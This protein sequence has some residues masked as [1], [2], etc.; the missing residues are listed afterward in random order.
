M[1]YTVHDTAA[2]T[3]RIGED[4]ALAVAAVRGAD[5]GL[6][7]LVL[8]GG[9]ARGEGMV[10]HG[11]P[12]NDYDFVAVRSGPRVDYE[13]LR[14]LLEG[15]LGLH[16]DLARV[17][18]AR[19]PW[20]RPSVFWYETALRGR[21]LWGEDLLDRI[22]VRTPARLDRAE[23]LRLLVNRAAGL[24]L[25]TETADP[26]AKRLQAAKAILAAADA[27][28]LAAGAFAPSQRERIALLDLLRA[29][30]ASPEGIGWDW[31]AWAFSH[32]VD[33]D[34]APQRDAREAWSA[35]RRALLDAVPVALAHAG[36]SSV[37]AY[38]R[39]DGVLDHVVY[40]LRSR[41]VAGAPRVALN[42]TGRVRV[43]TLHLLQQARD[44]KVP[45]GAA[46]SLL[47]PLARAGDGLPALDALRQATLQ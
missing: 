15:E 35:A 14:R 31:L 7:S 8:T 30:D 24:L 44:G 18:P 34:R 29:A 10:S 26:A 41:R 47:G 38:A 21:V 45:Q 16:V 19:L 23:G 25:C 4:L 42:P 40:A 3:R 11:A 46:R 37:D 39:S 27:R 6:R 33:P 20:V 13:A 9:F 1:A 36:L 22:P 32:K 5:P 17:S 12:Q 2:T 28:M 43:A